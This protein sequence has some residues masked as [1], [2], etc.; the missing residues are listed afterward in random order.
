MSDDNTPDNNFLND[1]QYGFVKFLTV[2]LLPASGT[3]YFSLAGLWG[4]PAAE[5]VLGSILAFETFIGVVL[6]VSTK[7]YNDSDA[8]YSGEINVHHAP[9]GKKVYSL[10]LN[11]SPEEIDKKDEA[12]FKVNKTK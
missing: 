11:H 1:K 2:I 9:S 12:V 3:L 10:D 7:Q 8:K 4:L 5:Q 6:G